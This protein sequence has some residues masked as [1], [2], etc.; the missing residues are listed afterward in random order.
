MYMK[1]FSLLF[2]FCCTLALLAYP[3]QT[4]A[5]VEEAA[6]TPRVGLVLGGGGAKALAHIGVLKY[7]EEHQIP[8]DFVVA[9]SM[10]A[11]AGGLYVQGVAPEKLENMVLS[12]DWLHL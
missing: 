10:G 1:Y 12:V 9:T 6:I 5:T 3:S 8:V 2:I 7:L 11:V 4:Q